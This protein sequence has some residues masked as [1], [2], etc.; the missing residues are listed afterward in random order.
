MYFQTKDKSECCACTACVSSCPKSCIRMVKDEEGFAY[1]VIDEV[2]CISCHLCERVCPVEHPNY[3]N[4]KTPETYAVLLKD[5]EERKKSSSGGAFYAIASF[6]L[7]KCG[8]VIGSTMDENLQVRHIT[9][10]SLDE[11]YKLRGSKYVQ[12][13]LGD[14]FS[15]I[16]QAL[17]D[18]RWCYFVGTGCQVAGLKSFLGKDY[19]TLITSDLVCHGVPSQKLFDQHVSYLEEKYHDRVIN[20]Q[21]RNNSSWGGCEIVDFENHKT[22][23]NPS[24]ELS[25]YLYSFMYAMT[26]RHSCYECR[27]AQ[28][29]RQGDITLADFWGV[30][31]F[32][33]QVD[34]KHGVS[35]V[36]VNTEQGE[37]AWEQSKCSFEYYQSTLIDGAKYNGN[38]VKKSE[39][40]SVRDSIYKQIEEKGYGTIAKTVFSSPNTFKIKMYNAINNSYIAQHF[41]SLYRMIKKISQKI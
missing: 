12:S 23:K 31:E 32:F 26:Y 2:N 10:E 11:L 27:F 9:I 40:P 36:L 29:P 38:L 41:L 16:R 35:L 25:P 20:Y 13:D 6:V 8:I 14:V 37:M 21:F 28:V 19:P 33:A 7:K 15:K 39:K 30:D 4:A 34:T 5:V 22:V 24:Y 1:P 18:N 3:S 17:K